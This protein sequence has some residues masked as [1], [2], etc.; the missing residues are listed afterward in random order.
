[1]RV[2]LGRGL[3]CRWYFIAVSFDT[4]VDFYGRRKAAYC[5]GGRRRKAGR[6]ISN[7]NKKLKLRAWPKSYCGS[8]RYNQ[9]WGRGEAKALFPDF[10]ARW[11]GWSATLANAKA[12]VTD[13]QHEQ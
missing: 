1:M 12:G 4:G 6:P 2:W 5:L 13:K 3:I 9:N 7:T 8:H 10:F 11:S